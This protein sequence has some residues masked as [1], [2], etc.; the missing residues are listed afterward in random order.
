MK[1]FRRIRKSQALRL[2]PGVNCAAAAAPARTPPATPPPTPTRC[3]PP[4][5]VW[6]RGS[7]P[8][9][10]ECATWSGKGQRPYHGELAR[11][12]ATATGRQPEGKSEGRWE[13]RQAMQA[14]VG[15]ESWDFHVML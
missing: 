6:S 13:G 14:E 1:V 2:V 7:Y 9:P 11:A 12:R 4:R 3:A 5:E 8:R 10:P 15:P